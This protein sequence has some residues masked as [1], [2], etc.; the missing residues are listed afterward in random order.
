M[1]RVKVQ[2]SAPGSERKVVESAKLFCGAL[3]L[4]LGV[5]TV[6]HETIEASSIVGKTANKTRERRRLPA[7]LLSIV[8]QV[9]GAMVSGNNKTTI[10]W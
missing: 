7:E 9:F 5:A 1:R 8:I 2:A 3:G 4:M 10:T 6:Q